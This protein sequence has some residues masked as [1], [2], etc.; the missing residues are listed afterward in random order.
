MRWKRLL[1]L[2]A[3]LPLS[4]ALVQAQ[5]SPAEI[6][7]IQAQLRLH[8]SHVLRPLRMHAKAMMQSEPALR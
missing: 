5:V 8:G 4:A 3:L 1:L 7:Q 6:A 2:F